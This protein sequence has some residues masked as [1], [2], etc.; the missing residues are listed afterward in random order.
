[1]VK[2]LFLKNEHLGLRFGEKK[3]IEKWKWSKKHQCSSVIDD[4][5]FGLCHQTDKQPVKR[6]D[7]LVFP[8]L[9]LK[10]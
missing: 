2:Y 3:T 7:R 9:Q 5:L 10:T 8:N 4:F 6:E 1:M